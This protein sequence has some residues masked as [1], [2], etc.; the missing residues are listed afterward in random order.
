MIK[1][2]PLATGGRSDA[3]R[4]ETLQKA[5]QLCQ[6]DEDRQKVLSRADAIRTIESLRFLIPYLETPALAEAA[7]LSVVELAHHRNLR[8]P[9]KDEVT[10]AL[11]SVISVSKDPELVERAQRYKNGQ[12]W[13][14]R[15]PATKG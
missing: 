15:K 8:E 9:N 11:D 1:L 2:G 7:S 6:R 5:M 3:D 13:E 4:L 10:K 12:T 14:R